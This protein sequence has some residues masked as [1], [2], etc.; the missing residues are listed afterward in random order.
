MS[1]SKPKYVIAYWEHRELIEPFRLLLKYRGEPFEDR[2]YVQGDP[3]ECSRREFVDVRDQLG[4]AFPGLPYLFDGDNIKMTQSKAMICHLGFKFGMMG[5]NMIDTSFVLMLI[6][7]AKDLRSELSRICYYP[8]QGDFEGEKR[9]FIKVYLPG[10]LHQWECFLAE[11][12]HNNRWLVAGN[13]PTVADF[14]LF[15]YV[16]QCLVL[17]PSA[18]SDF[19]LL[20]SYMQQ[21]RQIPALAIY[22][23]EEHHRR[24][25]NGKMARFGN[26]VVEYRSK[27]NC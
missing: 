23:K 10:Q 27:T 7:Q 25:I 13:E 9:T 5:S 12:I 4:L 1:E 18:L 16:D 24:P 17:A 19:P 26:T 14:V 3:P 21:F 15:E 20:M 11:R 2:V 22:L 8:T 6:D